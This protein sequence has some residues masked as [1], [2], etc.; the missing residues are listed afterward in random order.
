LISKDVGGE[1]WAITYD[2]QDQSLSGNVFAPSGGAPQ[3]VFCQRISDDGNPDPA[4]IQI[5]YSCSGATACEDSSCVQSD[6]AAIATV[7]F[8]GSF[9][10]P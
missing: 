7:T 8:P 10:Q 3:F 9:L 4:A 6:W 1:R 2:L 5:T